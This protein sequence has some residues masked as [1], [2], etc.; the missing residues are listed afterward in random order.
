MCP[1]STGSP[2]SSSTR[3]LHALE[4]PPDRA[5]RGAPGRRRRSR[6]RARLGAAVELPDRHAEAVVERLEGRRAAARPRRRSTA[7]APDRSAV[8]G[9]SASSRKDERHGREDR[10][11]LA[12]ERPP[13]RGRAGART[14][15]GRRG[16]PASPRC[17]ARR[18][19]S[20]P[21][22]SCGTAAIVLKRTSSAVRPERRDEAVGLGAQLRVRARHPLG[23]PVQ[24]DEYWKTASSSGRRR[25]RRRRAASALDRV[26]VDRTSLP[27]AMTRRPLPAAPGRGTARLVGRR[28]S[29][30]GRRSRGSGSRA[31]PP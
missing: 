27:A 17:A 1:A 31:P 8:P 19:G 2:S 30:R 6:S 21:C 26:E 7:A 22:R 5:P 10:G 11:P 23:P 18:A 13:A 25:R 15:W 28:R 16:S 29:R 20:S 9:A 4:R 14:G 3:D 24:P 12:L